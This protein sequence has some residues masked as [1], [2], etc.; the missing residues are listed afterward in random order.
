MINENKRMKEK[1]KGN[2]VEKRKEK[3]RMFGIHS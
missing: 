3:Y 1:Q 2:R